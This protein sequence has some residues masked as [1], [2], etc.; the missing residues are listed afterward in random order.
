M[1]EFCCNVSCL[2][3]IIKTD[4]PEGAHLKRYSPTIS[5]HQ[6]VG[7][8]HALAPGHFSVLPVDV[9]L[10]QKTESEL[11]KNSRLL[12]VPKCEVLTTR[13]VSKVKQMF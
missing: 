9:F 7:W 8:K 2:H 1:R 10:T 12:G 4:M 6:L 5:I 13:L 11:Q 3:N